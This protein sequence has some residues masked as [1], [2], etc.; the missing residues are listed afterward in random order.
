MFIYYFRKK[1]IVYFLQH[2]FLKPKTLQVV[3]KGFCSI[4]IYDTSV[5]ESDLVFRSKYIFHNINNR[6]HFIPPLHIFLRVK[7]TKKKRL[8]CISLPAFFFK[9]SK[10]FWYFYYRQAFVFFFLYL[11]LFWK[12]FW[13]RNK[14]YY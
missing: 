3:S 12:L 6:K 10:K 14:K 8:I 4:W 13:H 9:S 2:V 7:F 5:E 11:I 1:F